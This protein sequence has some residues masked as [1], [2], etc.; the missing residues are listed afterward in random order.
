MDGR[1]TLEPGAVDLVLGQGRQTRFAPGFPGPALW[2]ADPGA[3]GFAEPG[4]RGRDGRRLWV[5]ARRHDLDRGP[6]GHAVYGWL[7]RAGRRGAAP[8]GRRRGACEFPAVGGTAGMSDRRRVLICNER[9]LARF[10][11][12][13]ILV[14]LAEHLVAQGMEVSFAC[15]RCDRA[16]LAR[17]SAD[18]E[19]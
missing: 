6:V 2:R 16:V 5:A 4:G 18:V 19:E 9:F 10:G 8:S 7:P 1:R 11:V 17:I 13:R 15:L 3:R 12:D 14:L